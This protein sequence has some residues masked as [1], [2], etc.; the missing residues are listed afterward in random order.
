MQENSQ[1]STDVTS[2]S[3]TCQEATKFQTYFL[4]R[5]RALKLHLV[6]AGQPKKWQWR[7][8]VM[9]PDWNSLALYKQKVLIAWVVMQILISEWNSEISAMIGRLSHINK[10]SRLFSLLIF[11]S[12]CCEC[13]VAT[14]IIYVRCLDVILFQKIIWKLD[15]L[16]QQ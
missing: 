16:R 12:S 7:F 10:E 11:T 3:V 9:W 1:D 5:L 6:A 4:W 14:I 2:G 15:F 13:A 8:F